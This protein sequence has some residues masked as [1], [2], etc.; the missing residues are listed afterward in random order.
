MKYTAAKTASA[1]LVM[2]AIVG[3]SIRAIGK[4]ELSASQVESAD[5]NILINAGGLR[6]LGLGHGHDRDHGHH[7]DEE[8][9]A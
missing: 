9:V 7:D 3:G 1:A 2:C 6:R 5:A 8:E 4:S